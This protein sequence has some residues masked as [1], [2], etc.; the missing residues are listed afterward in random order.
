VDR[1]AGGRPGSGRGWRRRGIWTLCARLAVILER[2]GRGVE[3]WGEPRFRAAELQAEHPIASA[4]CGA[5]PDG[6]PRL[7]RPDLCCCPRSV[8]AGGRRRRAVGSRPPVASS[9]SAGRGRSAGLVS[10]VRHHAPAH[11]ALAVSRAASVAH[12]GDVIRVLLV[13]RSV[14][15]ERTIAV[16]DFFICPYMTTLEAD[17]IIT[18]VRIPSLAGWRTAFV[19]L[20][21]RSGDFALAG[22]AVAVRTRDDD[23]IEAAR[24]AANGVTST[25]VR[26]VAAEAC[27]L[28]A[29]PSHDCCDSAGAAAGQ[30]VAAV[31]PDA[32]S[33]DAT[34]RR[35]LVQTL[36]ARAV[37][38]LVV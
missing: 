14:C 36:T 33:A 9:R 2:E 6:R 26:L 11:V 16:G 5:L 13:A 32:A 23:V 35:S 17:E 4:S 10:E 28:G 15:G 22:I 8:L 37:R 27:L 12:A 7:R 29:D 31:Q 20:A 25:P 34:Y 19:E 3:V 21:R 38:S 24:T 30:D 18:A 1:D